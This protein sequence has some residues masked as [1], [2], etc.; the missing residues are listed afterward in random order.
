LGNECQ[1]RSPDRVSQSCRYVAIPAAGGG[2]FL[3][4]SVQP[5]D[6]RERNGVGRKERRPEYDSFA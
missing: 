4:G 3:L 1:Y 2:E 5:K 6:A